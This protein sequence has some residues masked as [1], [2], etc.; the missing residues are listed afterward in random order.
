MDTRPHQ[1]PVA[2]PLV[3]D[4]SALNAAAAL[5]RARVELFGRAI[6]AAAQPIIDAYPWLAW[7]PMAAELMQPE[8]RTSY[9]TD[10]AVRFRRVERRAERRRIARMIREDQRVRSGRLVQVELDVSQWVRATSLL[11]DRIRAALGH[12]VVSYWHEPEPLRLPIL[13]LPLEDT[14]G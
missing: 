13:H 1:P 9:R 12:T 11:A 5:A 7:H 10:P 4:W 2:V 6:A 3:V 8:P 14:R